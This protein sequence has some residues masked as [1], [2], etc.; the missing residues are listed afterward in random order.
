CLDTMFAFLWGQTVADDLIVTVC[1]DCGTTYRLKPDMAGKRM[2]CTDANCRAVF[3]VEAA[4]KP[5][6]VAAVAAEPPT[7]ASPASAPA[8][9]FDWRDAPPPVMTEVGS[10]PAFAHPKRHQ[11]IEESPINQP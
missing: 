10:G 4:T 9:V 1:P 2:R 7:V 6:L 3:L 11:V 8:P 5:E